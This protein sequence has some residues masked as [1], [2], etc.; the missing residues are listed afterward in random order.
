MNYLADTTFKPRLCGREFL[1]LLSL[2]VILIY[3]CQ[4]VTAQS[5]SFGQIDRFYI[6]SVVAAP[7]GDI[8]VHF[9]LENDEPLS[10]ISMPI[11]YDASLL[12]IKSISFSDSRAE[13]IGNKIITPSTIEDISGHFLVGM[14]IVFED[15]LPAGDGLIF[16]A[17]FNVSEAASNGTV[18][19]IDTLFYPPGGEMILVEADSSTIIKPA[20][21]PGKISVSKNNYPPVVSKVQEQFIFEG[22]SLV[23]N[24]TATDA[25]NDN[26]VIVC[27]DKPAG[28]I[29]KDNG[30][31]TGTLK[32]QPDYIGPYSSDGS[33]FKLNLWISD[34]DLSIA[35]EIFINVVNKNR[36][37]NISVSLTNEYESGDL[38]E[39]EISATDPDFETITWDVTNLP[40]NA[41]F[42]NENP[43]HF[44]WASSLTD[45]GAYD[46]R[47]IAAD[48]QGYADTSVVTL[49]LVSSAIYQLLLDTISGYP[50]EIVDV[51]VSL[52]NKLPIGSFDLLVNYD[53]TVTTVTGVTNTDTR[54]SG[55]EIYNTD[56][57]ENDTPGNI[58][59][60]GKVDASGATLLENGDGSI[61]KIS[62]RII[63]NISYAG[64]TAPVRFLFLDDLTLNDNTLTDTIGNKIEQNAIS[65]YDGYVG[66]LEM[67]TV[68]VGD[69]NLNGIAYDIGDAIYFTN[70]FMNP[71]SFPLNPLQY[72]NSD[73]N[74]DSYGGTIG[75]LVALIN[76]IISGDNSHGKNYSRENLEASVRLENDLNGFTLKGNTNFETGAVL[77]KIK[78]ESV[79]GDLA[80]INL[81]DGMTL[82]YYE[83]D[84]EIRILIYSL[85]GNWIPLGLNE[86]ISFERAET[87]ELVSVE[88]ATSD[89]QLVEVDMASKGE[90]LPVEFV[91]NQNYPNP[92]NPR[93]NISF[94]LPQAG[95][96]V[97]TVYNILGEKVNILIDKEM[98]AGSHSVEWNSR[99]EN[100]SV[101]ASGIYLYRLETNSKSE[102]RKMVLLK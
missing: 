93:T 30:D 23:L 4:I 102:T 37:P 33:P 63:S 26:L 2:L 7:G 5:D 12:T 57:D 85:E 48:P 38:I 19:S 80:I 35:D 96:V 29:F 97:L 65:Y 72:A 81:A 46:V 89:G 8:P 11:K 3:P 47:F 14:F 101:V 32:W 69:I 76:K 68:L 25:N 90:E 66:I 21:T 87:V 77:F 6:D 27:T 61:A 60:F 20:F 1:K 10:S 100:G 70:Y 92:F 88:M 67:G 94:S 79:N 52:D 16:T 40:T 45:T 53:P 34:G 13:Y 99:D 98:S 51:N 84:S 39:F 9:Y 44:S 95:K 78:A 17:L 58:R 75:D 56:I 18:L 59:I 62:F 42:D 24:I 41:V 50:G 43:A 54:A 55:F 71:I 91:L 36:K 64:L 28:A 15:P 73:V 82:D 83:S 22:D 74:G 86:L 31:G 49:K